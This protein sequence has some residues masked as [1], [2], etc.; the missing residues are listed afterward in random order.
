MADPN[1][2]SGERSVNWTITSVVIAVGLQ[3][4]GALWW[5]SQMDR[6]VTQLERDTAPLSVVVETVA[7]LDE[8]TGA[9]RDSALR[10]ERKLDSLEGV[11]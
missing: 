9:M 7:R 5:A 4:A 1:S 8:R 10:I 11:R 3:G 2:S 6:R